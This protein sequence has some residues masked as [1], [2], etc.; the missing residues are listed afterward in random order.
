M[1]NCADSTFD[2]EEW[3]WVAPPAGQV[4]PPKDTPDDLP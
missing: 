1:D 2:I 4:P 3:Q